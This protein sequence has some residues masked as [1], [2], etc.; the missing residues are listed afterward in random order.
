[1]MTT[2]QPKRKQTG[3]PDDFIE[4]VKQV[5]EHLYDFP[6]LQ[7]HPLAKNLKDSSGSS[8]EIASQ[9]L[10]REFIAAIETLNPGNSVPF[11]SPQIRPYHLLQLHHVEGMTTQEA[12]NELGISARQAYRDLR[13]GE[14]SVAAVLWA[15]REIVGP[16]KI[17]VRQVSSVQAEM[18]RLDSYPRSTDI[19][20]L[21]DHVDKAVA[22]LAA[23]QQVQLQIETPPEPV[24]A[25]TEPIIARQAL[26]STV[27]HAIQLAQPGQL[28]LHLATDQKEARLTLAYTL[29]ATVATTP[30]VKPIVAQLAD[31][32]GW[33][34][35]QASEAKNQY[36]ETWH[37]PTQGPM[38]LVIDD[39]EGLVE[40]LERY[41]TGQACRV[42]AA[43]SG[44]EGLRMAHELGPDV[45][46]LD[47]MMP[48]M[49]G[50]EV[51]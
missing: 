2:N 13:Q 19:N 34:V 4:Q 44:Q 11:R 6:Y 8:T 3:P 30:P 35:Q 1:M 49:D 38:I 26:V 9:R 40:L 23:Q 20:T 45:V 41:L 22:R 33:T 21:L 27:S 47:V 24:I 18:K 50:W 17:R 46:V 5:L 14:K 51:L 48:E 39:N 28:R 12:A 32:L 7:Q 29:K 36:T 42:A 31:R 16:Q 43:A 37:I 10:R 15:R 25:A